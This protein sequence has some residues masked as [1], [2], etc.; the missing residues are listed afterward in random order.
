MPP[1]GATPVVARTLGTDMAPLGIGFVFADARFTHFSPNP[2][3]EQQLG[4]ICTPVNWPPASESVLPW[5]VAKCVPHD[6]TPL[7]GLG[8]IKGARYFVEVCS[9]KPCDLAYELDCSILWRIP[10]GFSKGKTVRTRGGKPQGNELEPPLRERSR[11]ED[12]RRLKVVH[13][14]TLLPGWRWMDRQIAQKGC[15]TMAAALCV[16]Y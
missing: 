16:V 14:G 9:S 12:S 11:R 2:I 7:H 6:G 8:E 4:P 3:Y 10:G 13:R 15:D 1:V 5:C